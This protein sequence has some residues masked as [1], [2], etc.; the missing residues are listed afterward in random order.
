MKWLGDEVQKSEPMWIDFLLASFFFALF[1]QNLLS[2]FYFF[3]TYHVYYI[4]FEMST[5]KTREF[6]KRKKNIFNVEYFFFIRSIGVTIYLSK[7]IWWKVKY[8][9]LHYQKKLVIIIFFF[10]RIII[11]FLF[12]FFIAIIIYSCATSFCNFRKP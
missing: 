4:F 2:I 10:F 8:L 12:K 1:S 3:L 11:V 7:I 9:L 5:I 6:F